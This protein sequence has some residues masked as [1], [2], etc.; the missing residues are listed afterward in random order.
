MKNFTNILGT[1]PNIEYQVVV[2]SSSGISINKLQNI[3]VVGS[4]SRGIL[5]R[6]FSVTSEN[7]QAKLGKNNS[8]PS[9]QVIL[10]ILDAGVGK[11]NVMRIR[12]ANYTPSIPQIGNFRYTTDGVI[13]TTTD[14][15]ERTIL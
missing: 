14:G 12:G 3:V 13:R 6:I 10:D 11:V 5:G 2:D 15:I 9:Y 7:V 4:F 8:N 1:A